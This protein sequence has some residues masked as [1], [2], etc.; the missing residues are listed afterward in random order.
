MFKSDVIPWLIETG[1]DFTHRIDALVENVLIPESQL[2][3]VALL[4]KSHLDQLVDIGLVSII[5]EPETIWNTKT[6]FAIT[7]QLAFGCLDT[8]FVL[9]QHWGA[10]SIIQRA[11]ECPDAI[12]DGQS[13]LGV[14]FGHL[15]RSTPCLRAERVGTDLHITG[16][17]PWVTGSS[18]LSWVV[19][20]ATLPT[21]DHV[22]FR[23]RH[24]EADGYSIGQ[25][26]KLAAVRRTDTREVA[27]N[28]NVSSD[29]ILCVRPPDELSSQDEATL[30]TS[31]APILGLAARC[32]FDWSRDVRPDNRATFEHLTRVYQH[33]RDE[34][35]EVLSVLGAV[36]VPD[37][38]RVREK[39]HLLLETIVHIWSLSSGG[40]SN[41]RGMMVIRRRQEAAFFRVFQQTKTL[42]NTAIDSAL[43]HLNNQSWD[44][45][46]LTRH[47]EPEKSSV[48]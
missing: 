18:W 44:S 4:P 33:L 12:W 10:A 45:A 17:A 39:L 28:L 36:S 27:L 23:L 8:W 13:L 19:Y 40:Q 1:D 11:N 7:E 25:P 21:G 41:T 43:D 42:R 9:T 22:Y 31:M 2:D 32:L 46:S 6:K 26:Q 35:Y 14:G 29:L 15:R 37:R 34:V 20:G 47:T 38:L 3:S 48:T 16:T 30:V 5:T 24:I